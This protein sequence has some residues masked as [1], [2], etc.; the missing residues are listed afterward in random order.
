[1]K[2]RP[3]NINF[4]TVRPQNF[5]ASM[6]SSFQVPNYVNDITY[7]YLS[8]LIECWHD[9]WYRGGWLSY[10]F[11]MTLRMFKM[12]NTN[13]FLFYILLLFSNGSI[14]YEIKYVFVP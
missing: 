7:V 6:S 11:G 10:G 4:T 13:N 2:P 12:K 14:L 3:L 1:M 8:I 5:V 9:I